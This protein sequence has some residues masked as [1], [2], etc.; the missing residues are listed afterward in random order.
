MGL[1]FYMAKSID[2][3]NIDDAVIELCEELQE[4]LYKKREVIDFDIRCIYELDPYGDTELDSGNMENLIA[5][6]DKIIDSDYLSDY[7]E[8]EEERALLINLK[9]LCKKAIKN[10]LKVYAIGD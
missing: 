1:D 10:D 5:V 8:E 9:S 6:C 7:D 4:Y 2:S 3:I